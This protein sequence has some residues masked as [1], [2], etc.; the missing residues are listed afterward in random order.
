MTE[1]RNI[2]K[3]DTLLKTK[4]LAEGARVEVN[5]PPLWEPSIDGFAGNPH[6]VFDG[7]EITAVALPNPR[8]RLEVN[9]SDQLR[10]VFSPF[11]PLF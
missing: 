2:T 8:S 9:G 10:A 4:L 5:G 11:L 3:E 7:C 6:I 1:K